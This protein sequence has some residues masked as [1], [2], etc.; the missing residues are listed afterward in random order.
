M[1]HKTHSLI[2]GV[3]LI[4]VVL[5]ASLLVFGPYSLTGFVTANA[6]TTTSITSPASGAE[7]RPGETFTVSSLIGCQNSKCMNVKS[8]LAVSPSTGLKLKT[9]ATKSWSSI[10]AGSSKSASWLVQANKTGTYILTVSTSSKNG[11]ASSSS[12]QVIVYVPAC[13]S[14]ADCGTSQYLSGPYCSADGNVY[15]DYQAITC[16]YPGTRS[17]SCQ[18]TITAVLTSNCGQPGPIGSPF[19]VG[20]AVYQKQLT[21]GC[22]AGACLNSTAD[23]LVETCT[24]GCTA[25]ACNLAPANTCGDS[26]GGVN[27]YLPGTTS[28]QSNGTFFSH[29]D[30]CLSGGYVGEYSCSGTLEQV[31]SV[32]CGTDTWTGTPICQGGNIW[33]T[34]T[35][36]LC[37]S[38]YC[39][40]NNSLQ[41]YQPCQY[42]CS[43]STCNSAPANDS[44]TDSDGGYN[45]QVAGSVSGTKSGQ[46][47]IIADFC[48]GQSLQ[49]EYYCS[50]NQAYNYTQ[51]CPIGNGSIGT[52][53]SGR[54]V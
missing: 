23:M 52:C 44:C 10:L 31:S 3:V 32:S 14:N 49:V 41:L 37:G 40:T 20:S 12:I 36:Y 17:A 39:Q 48:I 29:N 6:V 4:T 50:G 45:Q 38:G 8:T 24:Y 27:I 21:V 13:N 1:H 22:S 54:C 35:D 19:C 18:S 2:P 33:R 34:F 9:S 47:F 46:Q 51:G 7:Y 16:A 53:T 28:G 5:V 42:G 26:D 11:Q 43:G 30:Y 25:G 15:R